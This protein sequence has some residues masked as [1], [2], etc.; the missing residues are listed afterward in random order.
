MEMFDPRSPGKTA[1]RGGPLTDIPLRGLPQA[2]QVR[3]WLQQMIITDN[4]YFVY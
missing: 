3:R 4:S 2:I 1:G